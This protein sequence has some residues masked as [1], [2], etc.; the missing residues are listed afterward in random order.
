M[1]PVIRNTSKTRQLLISGQVQGASFLK[2]DA[3]VVCAGLE[4]PGPVPACRYMLGWILAG[5]HNPEGSGLMIGL[6]SG[7]GAIGLLYEFP[8]IDLTVID[9]SADVVKT[10]VAAFPLLQFYMDT[11]RLDIR[12][13]DATKLSVTDKWDFGCCD[14]YTGADKLV[15]AVVEPCRAAT[16]QFWCNTIA[17]LEPARTV[18]EEPTAVLGASGVP[19]EFAEDVLAN[20]IVTDADIDWKLVDNFTPFADLGVEEVEDWWKDLT[21]VNYV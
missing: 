4:G 2:P 16:S 17:T 1:I 14:A 7:A 8:D 18:I 6:G 19:A 13:E 12:V 11:G 5:L 3:S 21:R 10:A 15:S 20:W 9:I